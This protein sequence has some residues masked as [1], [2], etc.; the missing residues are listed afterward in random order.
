MISPLPSALYVLGATLLYF[1]P[2]FLALARGH[3]NSFLL[4]IVNLSLGWTVIGWVGALFWS[5][6][7][8]PRGEES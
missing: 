2:T 4:A 1:L 5:L 7:K 6:R 8:Q 3:P